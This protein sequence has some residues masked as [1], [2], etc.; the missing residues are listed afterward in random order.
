MTTRPLRLALIGYGAIGRQIV[1]ALEGLP[2]KIVA[3]AMR[4]QRENVPH[5]ITKPEELLALKP[6][7]VVEAAGREAIHF[8]GEAALAA[9][10]AFAI[11]S[12]S[13]FTD[14]TLMAKLLAAAQLHHSQ[15]LI[16]PGALGA[17]DALAA[18]SLLP[19]KRVTHTIIKPARAW[20]GTHA[21]NLIKLENLTQAIS[22]FKGTAREAATLFPQNANVTVISSLAGIGLE[23]TKVQ[24]IADPH[25]KYNAHKLLA[26]GDFGRMRFVIENLPSPDNPKT[27]LL[28]ALSLVRLIK[29]RIARVVV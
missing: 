1:K 26:E 14:D 29:N 7:L 3:I 9:A 8:W 11:A 18:A 2:I 17:V 22:F 20:Q 19:L 27:S 28:T 16:P 21:E 5:L 4:E 25:A 6:D 23:K 12:T 15:I 13:A 10:P 24:L